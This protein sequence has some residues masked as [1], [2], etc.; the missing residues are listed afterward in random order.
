MRWLFGGAENWP[1]YSQVLPCLLCPRYKGHRLSNPLLIVSPHLPLTHT[2]ANAL[3]VS[4]L[5]VGYL[6]GERTVFYLVKILMGHS[7]WK[8]SPQGVTCWVGNG[9]GRG[10]LLD[11]GKYHERR[12][13]GLGAI[14]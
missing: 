7:V 1:D 11:L 14:C 3:A 10:E 8:S 2:S 13:A 6:R 12:V 9:R 5:L 4:G